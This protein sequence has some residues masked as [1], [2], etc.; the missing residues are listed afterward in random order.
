MST[1]GIGPAFYSSIDAASEGKILPPNKIPRSRI[2][3]WLC[4]D[5]ESFI[6]ANNLHSQ[7]LKSVNY[8][9]GFYNI[10]FPEACILLNYK[11]EKE[12]NLQLKDWENKITETW[13]S[14][15]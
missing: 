6:V 12:R 1:P 11:S 7:D 13:I 4:L 15:S 8:D 5:K 14:T 3:L 2:A 9:R 10:H